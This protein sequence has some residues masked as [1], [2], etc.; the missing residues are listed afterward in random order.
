LLQPNGWFA[1]WFCGE[2]TVNR[3]LKPVIYVLAGIYFVVDA[4]FM[5]VAEPVAD[6]LADRRILDGLRRWIVS[7]RPYPTLALFAVPVI[8][9]EPVKPIAAY[10]AATGHMAAG[11][12]IL[13]LGEILKLV[14]IERLF[15]LC[16]DRLMSIP[17]FAWSYRQYR[18]VRDWVEA[19]DAWQVVRR[20]SKIVQY[21][22]RV[23]VLELKASQKPLRIS[24]QRR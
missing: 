24:F 6:W 8:I 16:H 2:K 11:L 23:Y 12:A 20:W 7:L 19:T 13:V 1:I 15:A 10:L 17:A 4:V 9:L 14:L 3:F 5:I 21:R 18:Q 22:V